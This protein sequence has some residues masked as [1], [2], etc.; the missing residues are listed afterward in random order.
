MSG[1]RVEG[2]T[3]QTQ[4]DVINNADL[5]IITF[6]GYDILS[7]RKIK[8]GKYIEKDNGRFESDGD[9]FIIINV[10]TNSAIELPGQVDFPITIQSTLTQPSKVSDATPL[11]M[12]IESDNNNDYTCFTHRETSPAFDYDKDKIKD[13]KIFIAGYK[14]RVLR[15]DKRKDLKKY[16]GFYIWDRNDNQVKEPFYCRPYKLSQANNWE[17]KYERLYINVTSKGVLNPENIKENGSNNTFIFFPYIREDINT[18]MSFRISDMKRLNRTPLLWKGDSPE[19]LLNY[20]TDAE[21]LKYFCQQEGK[22]KVTT[23]KS[24]LSNFCSSIYLE[25]LKYQFSPERK[26]FDNIIQNGCKELY[27]NGYN[28][29]E[30]CQC[31]YP[32][33]KYHENRDNKII[34]PQQPICYSEKCQVVREKVYLTETQQREGCKTRE[35]IVED[36][37]S[38]T[39]KIIQMCNGKRRV[40]KDKNESDPWWDYQDDIEPPEKTPDIPDKGEL[41][42][43]DDNIDENKP[44][45]PSSNNDNTIYFILGGIFIISIIVIFIFII[46]RNK[47]K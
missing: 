39:I 38:D 37:D 8:M 22:Y 19:K 1:S 2:I 6:G 43:N 16:L 3:Y 29:I 4:S 21:Q 44:K 36:I 28:N 30:L 7:K 11:Y 25:R 12:H 20:C 27:D 26:A 34:L 42:T 23:Y 18:C 41:P 9:A 32:V 31:Q 13:R 14:G 46:R 35:C 15:S 10:E 47:K 40:F 17:N 33:Y 5:D 24:L 45:S